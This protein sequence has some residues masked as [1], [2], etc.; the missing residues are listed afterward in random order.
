MKLR[1]FVLIFVIL[2]Y[3]SP[4]FSQNNFWSDM[5]D[6]QLI[7]KLLSEMDDE[8]LLAQTFMLGY[9]GGEPS[10]EILEWIR[11]KEIGGVKIFGWNVGSL[12]QLA[13]S[14][15]KMQ[16]V[17]SGTSFKIPLFIVTDQE[18]GWVRHIHTG[19]TET[20][21][22]MSLGATRIPADSYKTGYYIG[23]E[24]RTLGINMNFA[25]TVDVYSNADAHVIGPRAFSDDPLI[26][27][28]L[29]TAYY[30]GMESSGIICTAKHYPGH[31][32]ADKDSHGALPIIKTDRETLWDRDLLPYRYLVK[33]GI[34]AIMSGHLA[35]PEITGNKIPAS[36]SKLFLTDILREKI[37]FEGLIITDDIMMNGVQLLPINTSEIAK[38]AISAGN[39]IILM[40]REGNIHSKVWKYLCGQLKSDPDFRQL[41][42][43]SARRI[44]KT[45]LK[46]L[47]PKDAVPL[48]PDED[49][50]Y[51]LL[52]DTE[53]RKF[54]FD[55]ALRSAT[56]IRKSGEDGFKPKGRILLAGQLE[57]FLKEGR[58]EY[59]DAEVF[60]F[61]YNP[62]YYSYN[63]V[64]K[65]LASIADNYDTIIYCLANPNSAEVLKSIKDTTADIIVLSVLTPIYLRDMPWV[66]NA[67][68]VYG[69]SED[70]F[71]AGFAVISGK[72]DTHG[73][74][75]ISF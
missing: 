53:S 61:G 45:K 54:F 71:T 56:I 67:L 32:N 36:L 10:S 51:S 2:F 59:P 40:S 9:M 72:I 37:G 60:K 73:K 20:S 31:G 5:D 6:D 28:I 64:Q 27:S 13:G 47:K 1:R 48:Y 17:S 4:L 25:P 16:R 8:Q 43:E 66:D 11:E 42:R 68:A 30:K 19:T 52:P 35:F 21:G 44:L 38:A 55:Q 23:M 24:L 62:F 58:K 14:V 46:Y 12:S 22:N 34:P 29:S 41:V 33:E 3:V 15:S 70:S 50:L 74:L 63:S 69:I 49:E 65:K 39:D 26:T 18:G 75:P 7:E 57:R